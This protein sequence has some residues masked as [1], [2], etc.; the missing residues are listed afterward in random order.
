MAKSDHTAFLMLPCHS[1]SKLWRIIFQNV[2]KRKSVFNEEIFLRTQDIHDNTLRVSFWF[3]HFLQVKIR[4]FDNAIQKLW[5]SQ[6]NLCPQIS[7]GKPQ[8]ESC[9]SSW[10][11]CKCSPFKNLQSFQLAAE[12]R[13]S[14]S[15]FNFSLYTKSS[16]SWDWS[17]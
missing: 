10:P 4:K 3:Y 7:T 12:W 14:L 2:Q 5:M 16:L 8:E 6:G 1:I 11:I 9:S 15:R 13:V 17:L